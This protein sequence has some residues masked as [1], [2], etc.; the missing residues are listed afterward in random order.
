MQ[1][2]GDVRSVRF[3]ARAAGEFEICQSDRLEVQIRVTFA[4]T[5]RAVLGSLRLTNY[6]GRR[7]EWIPIA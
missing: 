3:D 6:C 1:Q 4:E 2:L 5:D 7:L